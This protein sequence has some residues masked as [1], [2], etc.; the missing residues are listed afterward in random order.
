MA[1]IKL[2]NS[3]FTNTINM[4]PYTIKGKDLTNIIKDGSNYYIEAGSLI[5]INGNQ[6]A[7]EGDNYLIG[8]N[9]NNYNYIGFEEINKTFFFAA[10]QGIYDFDKSAYYDNGARILKWRISSNGDKINIAQ[11]EIIPND[12]NYFIDKQNQAILCNDSIIAEKGYNCLIYQAAGNDSV[13]NAL[14][15]FLQNTYREPSE[16]IH[17][18]LC[19][20]S[21]RLE[22][23][24][25]ST[26]YFCST[27]YVYENIDT[28]L[29]YT[30]E[31]L[32]GNPSQINLN[33]TTA[34]TWYIN[35]AFTGVS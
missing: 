27:C 22:T 19:F 21:I 10:N 4:I 17:R 8:E 23:P 12:N 14:R 28:V 31:P 25:G 33:T 20:G 29:L 30:I 6:Y 11:K 16:S 18:I 34:T 32:S 26:T 7:V 2:N 1:I 9:T 13:R 5:E 35:L 15:V 3:G 24:G